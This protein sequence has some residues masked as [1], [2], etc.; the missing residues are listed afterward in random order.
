MWHGIGCTPN[1]RDSYLGNIPSGETRKKMSIAHSG[2]RNHN[3]GKVFSV[4]HR[5]KIAI[6]HMKCRVDGYCDAW[7]DKEFKDDYRKN[8]C[9]ICKVSK[10]IAIG[11]DGRPFSNLLLHHENTD[12]QDC[13]PKNLRTLCRSC[14]IKLHR[15]LQID[16]NNG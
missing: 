4:E 13:N 11:R 6:G 7:S 5:Q 12:K 16:K 15:K 3:Y 9:E 1:G 10:K 8:Y 2:E 14:H